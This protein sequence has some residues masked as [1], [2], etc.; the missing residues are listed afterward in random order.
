MTELR[1]IVTE[2]VAELELQRE[3]VWEAIEQPRLQDL[4][5]GLEIDLGPDGMRLRRY[6]M[7]ADRLFR[8]AW[9]KLERL[10]KESGEPMIRYCK[11]GLAAALS[12]GPPLLLCHSPSRFLRLGDG[13]G[14]GTISS[15]GSTP[16][17]PRVRRPGSISAERFG[18]RARLLGR[19]P[20]PIRHQPQQ[21][22]PEQDEPDA[23]PARERRSSRQA[24]KPAVGTPETGVESRSNSSPDRIAED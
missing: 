24:K 17:A 4:H 22:A 5:A 21:S 1:Q 3:D 15:S 19:R 20:A 12:R 9:T 7:A 8:S 13:T 14:T 10:R 16:G 2:E 23:D 11:N 6:E 18:V